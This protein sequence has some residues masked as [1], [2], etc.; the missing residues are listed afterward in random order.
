MSAVEAQA[1]LMSAYLEVLA[2]EREK[3]GLAY[4]C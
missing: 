4:I 1:I 3:K 2:D